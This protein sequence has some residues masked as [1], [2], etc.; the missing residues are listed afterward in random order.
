MNN[1][2]DRLCWHNGRPNFFADAP[3]D[4]YLIELRQRGPDDF[5]VR[6]GLQWRD[7]LTYEQAA[8]ELGACIMHCA[9]LD[10]TLDN[11]GPDEG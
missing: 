9:A 2:Y 5:A 3:A 7:G 8:T 10:G 11:S 1:G 4:S 6:Y